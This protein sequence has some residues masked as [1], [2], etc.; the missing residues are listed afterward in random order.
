MDPSDPDFKLLNIHVPQKTKARL[1]FIH[2]P[3][4][5]PDKKI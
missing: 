5:G 3:S 4:I 1:L 2:R